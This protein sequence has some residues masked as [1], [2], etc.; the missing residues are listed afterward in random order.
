MM[1]GPRIMPAV[2]VL[3][4]QM[5]LL[6]DALNGGK[7]MRSD[8][9]ASIVETFPSVCSEDACVKASTVLLNQPMDFIVAARK[10]YAMNVNV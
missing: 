8:V 1:R 3:F 5:A 9:I 6:T 7:N 4:S 10:A 2:S